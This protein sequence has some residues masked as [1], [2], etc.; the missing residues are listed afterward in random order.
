MRRAAF[1]AW[2]IL[3]ATYVHPRSMKRI[4]ALLLLVAICSGCAAGPNKQDPY[5]SANR[6]VYAFNKSLDTAILKPVAKGYVKVFPSIARTGITN[7]Y[8]NLGLIVTSFNNA[9]QFKLEK[10]PVDVM[11]FT[12]NIFLGLDGILENENLGSV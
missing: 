10:V 11:R 12:T 4:P 6:K 7:F 2:A 3:C 1:I 9:L 8:R 5:E